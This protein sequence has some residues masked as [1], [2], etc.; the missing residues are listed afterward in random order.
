MMLLER[1]DLLNQ[2]V[3]MD[4]GRQNNDTKYLKFSNMLRDAFVLW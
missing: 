3:I 4:K 1:Y 2:I